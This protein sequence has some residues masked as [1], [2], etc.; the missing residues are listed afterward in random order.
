[1]TTSL[2]K[3]L[4]TA[5]A[6]SIDDDFIRYFTVIEDA[7]HEEDEAF[8]VNIDAGETQCYLSFTMA[9]LNAGVYNPVNKQWTVRMGDEVDPYIVILYSVKPLGNN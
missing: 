3:L 7:W 5:D 9:E 4:Q 6:V 8:N 2:F 1:M